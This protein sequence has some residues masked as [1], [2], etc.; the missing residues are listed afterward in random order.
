M[1]LFLYLISYHRHANCS[2]STEIELIGA[3]DRKK[4]N[5]HQS[6][7]S[8]LYPMNKPGLSKAFPHLCGS[9]TQ[10]VMSRMLRGHYH[11]IAITVHR[12]HELLGADCEHMHEEATKC[13]VITI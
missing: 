11:C 13:L 10:K 9:V 3:V 4:T 6:D 1:W 7:P 5:A 2:G 8:L 12:Q